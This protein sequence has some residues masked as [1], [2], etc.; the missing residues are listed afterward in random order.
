MEPKNILE[1]NLEG[2]DLSFEIECANLAW[3][4]PLNGNTFENS[5]KPKCYV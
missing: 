5:Y 1:S 4:D 2:I 3:L